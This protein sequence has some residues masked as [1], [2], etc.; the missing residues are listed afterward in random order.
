MKLENLAA[1]GAR[2]RPV[3][4]LPHQHHTPRFGRARSGLKLAL[5]GAA[6]TAIAYAW[7]STV[8]APHPL[9]ECPP[10]PGL[11]RES[12]GTGAAVEHSHPRGTTV[13]AGAGTS[14]RTG[15]VHGEDDRAVMQRAAQQP[16]V[17]R[18]QLRVAADPSR[19]DGVLGEGGW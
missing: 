8:P 5:G 16:A 12:R 7:Y 2:S 9:P 10:E 6:V 14:V 15:F 19:M 18:E 17:E 13:E 1:T 4:E 3:A 11:W